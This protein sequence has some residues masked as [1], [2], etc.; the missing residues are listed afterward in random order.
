MGNK[1]NL[2]SEPTNAWDTEPVQHLDPWK[3][4]N[5][6]SDAIRFIARR[7]IEADPRDD[8]GGLQL[9]AAECILSFL[10]EREM[11]HG[12]GNRLGQPF[13]GRRISR[14]RTPAF[15]LTSSRSIGLARR[16]YDPRGFLV[17]TFP[18][19]G[20]LSIRPS[21]YHRPA[22]S[23]SKQPTVEQATRSLVAGCSMSKYPSLVCFPFPV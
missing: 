18:R 9:F 1:R 17:F 23:L 15:V 6:C 3:I 22:G 11:G 20:T 5:K 10:R 12:M 16:Y 8:L 19:M 14:G 13:I 7:R 21:P 2:L 4:T